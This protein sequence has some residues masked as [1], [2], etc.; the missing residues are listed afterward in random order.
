MEQNNSNVHQN[1]QIC[2]SR[3]YLRRKPICENRWKNLSSIWTEHICL[4]KRAKCFHLDRL[5]LWLAGVKSFTV[6]IT[7][8]LKWV[9]PLAN[10][11]PLAKLTNSDPARERSEMLRLDGE[12]EVLSH[13]PSV[14]LQRLAIAGTAAASEA[15]MLQSYMW[16]W[17]IFNCSPVYI[18]LHYITIRKINDSGY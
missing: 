3:T 14:C 7:S 4:T 9:L 15:G 11:A 6:T 16:G 8:A 1:G 5:R 10:D 13:L 2:K 12:E 18:I 17:L